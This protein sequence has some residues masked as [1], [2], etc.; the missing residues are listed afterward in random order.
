MDDNAQAVV[1]FWGPLATYGSLA[2][3]L[4]CLAVASWLI[5]EL[6]NPMYVDRNENPIPRPDPKSPDRK[7]KSGSK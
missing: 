6:R 3:A 4:I 5:Y 1:R 2:L 7:A